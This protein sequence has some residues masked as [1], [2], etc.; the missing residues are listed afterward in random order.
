MK[1]AVKGRYSNAELPAE[2]ARGGDSTVEFAAGQEVDVSDVLGEFLLR[3]SPG[4][5]RLVKSGN[6]EAVSTETQTGITAPDRRARGGQ[7]R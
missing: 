6:L 1:L 5:F 7:S 2:V 3:D 4:T